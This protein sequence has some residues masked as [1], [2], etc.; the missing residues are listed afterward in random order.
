MT[1]QEAQ[2]RRITVWSQLRQI[3]CET[4]TG[5]KITK[6]GFWSDSRTRSWV[7]TPVPL[8]K[9]ALAACAKSQRKD[10]CFLNVSA[11]T[12]ATGPIWGPHVCCLNLARHNVIFHLCNNRKYTFLLWITIF[13]Y[14]LLWIL[15]VLWFLGFYYFRI[16]TWIMYIIVS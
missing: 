4:L 3:I 15:F 11:H 7:K 1:S 2:I 6:N 14:V 5:K 9:M 12:N 13:T 16:I 10:L 8:K